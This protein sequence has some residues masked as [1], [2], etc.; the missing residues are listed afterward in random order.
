MLNVKG[1]DQGCLGYEE[2]RRK[3]PKPQLGL[4]PSETDRKAR[5]QVDLLVCML[6]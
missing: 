3:S 6:C 2:L 1:T 4:A 5:M